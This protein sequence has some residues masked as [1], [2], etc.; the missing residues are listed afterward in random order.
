MQVKEVKIHRTASYDTPSNT[1]IGTVEISGETGSQTIRLSAATIGHIFMLLI[2]DA[3]STA[4]MNAS[5]VTRAL[6]EGANERL[7]LEMHEGPI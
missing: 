6:E 1:L 5:L 4:T 2:K 3:Q 7:I